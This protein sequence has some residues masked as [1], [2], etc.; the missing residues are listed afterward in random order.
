MTLAGAFASLLYIKS[1]GGEFHSV[2]RG[3]DLAHAPR[4]RESPDTSAR[5]R[6]PVST[7]GN[8]HSMSGC[9][10][11]APLYSSLR[12][13]Q[14]AVP[15][16]GVAFCARLTRQVA[17][18]CP[19]QVHALSG[20]S[21]TTEEGHP[22]VR[23][24]ALT[25][26][27]GCHA[28]AKSD[29]VASSHPPPEGRDPRPPPFRK[30]DQE[31]LPQAGDTRVR[32]SHHVTPSRGT[33]G[34]GKKRE[35]PQALDPKCLLPGHPLVARLPAFLHSFPAQTHRRVCYTSLTTSEELLP[36]H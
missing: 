30:R 5:L 24:A 14:F 29:P 33:G 13:Q 11:P 26:A 22:P 32:R 25:L 35:S 28:G 31:A 8:T 10:Y 34:W 23:L 3:Y 6:F 2:Q 27:P 15:R 18:P 12:E 36:C 4:I 19:A 1:P 7:T 9:H 21:P 17:P 20:P 16:T